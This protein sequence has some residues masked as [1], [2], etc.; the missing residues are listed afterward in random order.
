MRVWRVVAD[1][2][3]AASRIF[4]AGAPS[5]KSESVT[6]CF[7]NRPQSLVKSSGVHP[8]A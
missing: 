5:D 4:N 7:A 6:S 3:R 2:P 1:S 8:P